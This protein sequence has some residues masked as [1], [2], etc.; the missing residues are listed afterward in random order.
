MQIPI[1]QKNMKKTFFDFEIIAFDF[2]A[3]DTRFYWQ[4]ILAIVCQYVNKM[5]QDFRYY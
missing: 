1:M 5:S 3:L 2:V 4:K